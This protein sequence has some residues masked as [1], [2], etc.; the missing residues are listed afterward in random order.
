MN[1]FN[2]AL[3]Q[4]YNVLIPFL[5]KDFPLY[6]GL[7]FYM[8]FSVFFV[9]SK[10]IKLNNKIISIWNYWDSLLFLSMI[11]V[12]SSYSGNIKPA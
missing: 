8:F 4:T 12:K 11:S 9:K 10:R 3:L 2:E 7:S 6:I 1:S 5:V